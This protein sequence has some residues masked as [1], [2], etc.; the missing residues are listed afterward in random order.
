MKTNLHI[1]KVIF[2]LL[3]TGLFTFSFGQEKKSYQL[4]VIGFYNLEN[5]Y[6]TLDD[7]F[8]NDDEFTPAGPRRY[9]SE[10]YK[11]KI[12][13]LVD[14]IA[15]IGKEQSPDG[16]SMFGV[17]EIE[18]EA[19]LNDLIAHPDLSPRGYKVVHYDS[20]DERGVDVG[21]IYNPKYY[22]VEGSK[23][24]EVPLMGENG[25]KRKTRDVLWVWGK[26]MGEDLHVFVNHW[27]SRRGGEEASAP[28]RAA[29]AKVPKDII[30]SLTAINPNVKAIVMGDLN[31]D[32]LSP[33]VT[34]VLQAKNKIDKIKAGDMYNP[35]TDFYKN[36]IGTLAY[37]DAW[38]LF[39]QIIIT[40]GFLDKNQNGIFY[41]DAHI[42]KREFMVQ[43]TGRFKGYPL[44]TWDG[45]IYNRGF[46]DHFPT[47]IV[48]LKA[49]K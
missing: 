20:P 34:K 28:G 13:R 19:V 21:F 15:K 32:P 48:V 29:A 1:M 42:F 5:F 6:D 7:P 35:W 33:S 17:A 9:S 12:N 26:Y 4:G 14:V 25:Y 45:M 8:T 36:G 46:S 10:V 44:R 24:L 22:K 16:M 23:S 38:N 3:L 41:K 27:P 43:Q 11:D 30:D 47:Y 49:V 2:T 37:N 31:D 40:P 18:N 39:D